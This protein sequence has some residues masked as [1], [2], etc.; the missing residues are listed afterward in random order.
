MSKTTKKKSSKSVKTSKKAKKLSS[1]KS[2][3][4]QLTEMSPD[5]RD[6]LWRPERLEYLT[7][8]NKGQH[9]DECVFCYLQKLGESSESLILATQKHSFAVMNRFPYNNGHVM[10]L[11]KR[12]IG[13]LTELKEE[14]MADVMNLVRHSINALRKSYRKPPDGM[15]VG[16][17][18]GAAGGA[19]IPGHLHVHI[20]PRWL[21]DANFFPLIAKTKV[22]SETLEQTYERLLPYFK[23]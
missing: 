14:E 7:S 22:I 3:K 20:V 23:G 12:H 4:D 9:N 21:G 13:D 6:I 1:K 11:P 16:I 19:G 17:N 8:P 18:L 2:M 5:K 15:N 10:V